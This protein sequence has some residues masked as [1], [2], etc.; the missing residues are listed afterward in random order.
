MEL[1]Q[2][3]VSK[4]YFFFFLICGCMCDLMICWLDWQNHKISINIKI[5]IKIKW[6]MFEKYR[7]HV[8]QRS[9]Y[10]V[11]NWTNLI[12][13]R[14]LVQHFNFIIFLRRNSSGT[15]TRTGAGLLTTKTP[16]FLSCL[17]SSKQDIWLHTLYLYWQI[18]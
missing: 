17:Q 5:K 4:N 2:I 8:E 3:K 14:V 11:Q 15:P 12:F 1:S 13:P 9:T 16:P 18:I 7:K 6:K 10:R